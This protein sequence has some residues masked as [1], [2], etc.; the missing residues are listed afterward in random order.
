MQ[1]QPE[2]VR[3]I[4][5]AIADMIRRYQQLPEHVKAEAIATDRIARSQRDQQRV[6]F[7]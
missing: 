7:Q 6:R 5:F 2:V 3:D 4:N 1:K